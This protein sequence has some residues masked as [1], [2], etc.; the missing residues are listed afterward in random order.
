MVLGKDKVVSTSILTR[1][2]KSNHSKIYKK[3]RHYSL[4]RFHLKNIQAQYLLAYYLLVSLIPSLYFLFTH[5]SNIFGK[6]CAITFPIGLV[7]LILSALK[8]TGKWYLILFP[9]TFINAFQIVLFYLFGDD[10]IASDMFLNVVTTNTSE[11]N[12]LLGSLLPSIALV[13]G[14]YIPPIIFAILQWKQKNFLSFSLRKKL[15]PIAAI[16][17][18]FSFGF[19]LL[20]KK[21]NGS[22]FQYYTD[23]YPINA[24]YN[25][26]YAYDKFNKVKNYPV[27]SLNFKYQA[28]RKRE[29]KDRQIIVLIVGETSRADNWG[30]YGYSRNTT[31]LLEKQSNLIAFPDAITQANATHKSVSMILSSNDANNYNEIYQR[32]G[33][34]E[35]FKESDFKT[36][37]ISNQAENG[38]FIE[39]FTKEADLYKTL[40]VTNTKTRVVENHFDNEL[41]PLME[42]EIKENPGNLFIIIHSYGSHFKYMER[43]PKAFQKFTPDLITNVDHFQKQRLVNAYDNSILYTDYFLSNTIDTLKKTKASTLMMY[44]SDH[45]EDLFD[46]KRGK[47]LH[48]SPTPT[49]YQLR[50]PMLLWYS[51]QYQQQHSDK[52]KNIHQHQSLPVNTSIIFS[53]LLEAADISSPYLQPH[54]SIINPKFS[55]KERMYLNDHDQAVWY[56]KLNLKPQD[57][58]MIKKNKIGN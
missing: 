53:T 1:L 15:I 39:Y 35:A 4:M 31:P 5:P 52:I 6:L 25:L 54:L 11:I 50:I 27:S 28:T 30:L 22:K 16:I 51:D 18:I 32:K 45:G 14:L 10:V 8:N 55:L 2:F 33:I 23:V 58:E 57:F 13:V 29:N 19:S 56:Q 44:T 26:K 7:L 36:I 3:K 24:F 12:E 48:S 21:N 9:L 41:V 37:C 38:S 34:V 43:Y 49:Y 46:D 42:K 47:F 20:A 40:R 17:L